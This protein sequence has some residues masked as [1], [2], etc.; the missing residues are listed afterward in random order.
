MTQHP[1]ASCTKRQRDVFELIAIG[2]DARHHPAT[3]AALERKRL[4]V[5]E[6][7]TDRQGW[8]PVTI[9]RY[10]VPL[11]LHIQWCAWCSENIGDDPV[12]E[13]EPARSAPKPQ[14]SRKQARNGT[15]KI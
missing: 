13:P 2:Q 15:G 12:E 5:A 4:I 9:K 8:P 10:H 1:A 6:T 7:E 14:K 11:A 3:L